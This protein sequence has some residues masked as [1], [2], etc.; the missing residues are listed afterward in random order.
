MST[1]ASTEQA[2]FRTQL[3]SLV[4]PITM[5]QFMLAMVSATDALMHISFHENYKHFNAIEYL[6][7]QNRTD[8][9]VQNSCNLLH[10]EAS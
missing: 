10:L 6:S 9:S 1:T 7:T 5:Q 8:H 3:R 4:L 2:S